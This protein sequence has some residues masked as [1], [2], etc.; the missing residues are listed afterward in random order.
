MKFSYGISEADYLKAWKVRSKVNSG[1]KVVK[2]VMF[3]VFILVALLVLWMVVQKNAHSAAPQTT[4]DDVASVDDSSSTLSPLAPK[5]KVNQL[6]INV[7]PFVLIAGLWIWM[8]ARMGPAKMRKFYRSDPGMKGRY[9]VEV[10]PEFIA[11]E[12]T[13]GFSSRS[14]WNI[15]ECWIESKD[16]VIL[17]MRSQAHFIVGLSELSQGQRDELRTILSTA[18]A[19][20]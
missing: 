7:G 4:T 14:S 19:K 3:W 13:A 2:V 12:N 10:M 9:T 5:S 6:V 1:P 18:L 16:L 8:L 17:V 11:I 15:Y 20:K